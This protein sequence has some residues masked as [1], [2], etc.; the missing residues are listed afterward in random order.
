MGDTFDRVLEVAKESQMKQICSFVVEYYFLFPEQKFLQ[1]SC[2]LVF[3]K[4]TAEGGE[5]G[6]WEGKLGALKVY[7]S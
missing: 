1:N 4:E 2:W 6:S 7:F 3:E 5:G